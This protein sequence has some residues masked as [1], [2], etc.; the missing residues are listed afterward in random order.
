MEKIGVRELKNRTS[1]VLKR[2]REDLVEYL[3]TLRGE[4]VAVLRPLTQDEAQRIHHERMKDELVSLR[5]LSQQI[6]ESW[7]SEKSAVELVEEQ[8][9]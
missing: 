7:V 9:R 8:R 4:P 1:Y 6:A 3:V 2:V 5:S